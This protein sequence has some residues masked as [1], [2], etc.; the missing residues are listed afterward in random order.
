MCSTRVPAGTSADAMMRRGWSAGPHPRRTV[1]RRPSRDGLRKT[2]G[3]CPQINAERKACT[4]TAMAAQES[5]R[6]PCLSYDLTRAGKSQ[7]GSRAHGHALRTVP[8]SDLPQALRWSVSWAQNG[9]CWP[10]PLPWGQAASR[11]Q[12]PS[13]RRTPSQSRE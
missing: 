7:T 1:C 4:D 5:C 3:A 8:R 9:R 6:R 12:A 13:P 10:Q 2:A 11:H